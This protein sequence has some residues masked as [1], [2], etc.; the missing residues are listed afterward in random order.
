MAL[1]HEL[2]IYR[3]TRNLLGQTLKIV[4]NLPRIGLIWP[5][6]G[7]RFGGITGGK[8]GI[9]FSAIIVPTDPRAHFKDVALGTYRTDVTG[10]TSKTDYK[11]R[12]RVT[13]RT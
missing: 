13:R 7:G 1:H 9:P 3:D 11:Q 6:Q 12:R 5:E 8:E 10:A 2:P 4:R